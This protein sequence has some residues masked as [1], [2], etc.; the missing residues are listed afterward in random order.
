MT[1]ALAARGIV[2][3][4][5]TFTVTDF[6][7]ADLEGRPTH[8]LGKFLLLDHV[9]ANR[10]G[11]PF[12]AVRTQATAIVDGQ[13]D[14][15]Q[16]GARMA[17]NLSIELAEEYGVGFVGLR[18][19]ARFSR[20]GPYARLIAD[21]GFVAICTNNAGPPA[22]APFGSR[23][24]I[25]GTN[26]I[27]FAFPTDSDAFV[28]DFATSER[29]WGAIRQAQ[30]EK[31]EL[32][33]GAFIDADGHE[34]QNPNEVNAVLPFDGAKGSALCIAI[35]LIAGTLAG[36]SMGLEV[37]DEYS[38]GAVFLAARPATNGTPVRALVS[39]LLNEIR[40][41]SALQPG[42]PVRAPGDGSRERRAATLAD[43]TIE[44]D[45]NALSILKR[46]AEGGKGLEADKLTN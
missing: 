11:K 9:L 30:L 8:G 43:G 39:H 32:P 33:P 16:T 12:V 38:L 14:I 24:P 23:D 2:G 42:R 13:R 26:P 6:L 29:V 10:Q 7:D 5:A 19:S 4:D 20:L 35:E 3:D 1:R 44:V 28:I 37:Q 45:Q 21:H 46:M 31:R 22:V 36:A 18:N 15:G 27:A 34:T 25:L 41:S 17:A 40:A